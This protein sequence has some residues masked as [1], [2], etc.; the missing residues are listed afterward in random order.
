MLMRKRNFVWLLSG[1]IFAFINL[2]F[3]EPLPTRDHAAQ[4]LAASFNHQQRLLSG[5][6]I[7]TQ[8]SAQGDLVHYYLTLP[9]EVF[10]RDDTELFAQQIKADICKVEQQSLY[11]GVRVKL[12]IN[13]SDGESL[14]QAIQTDK[15]CSRLP[16]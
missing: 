5:K 11:R 15:D 9:R 6:P 13:G 3:A 4:A 8:A 12:V 7:A 2:A 16:Y 10:S 14:Y 1:S